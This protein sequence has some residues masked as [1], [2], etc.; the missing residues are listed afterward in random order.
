MT[1]MKTCLVALAACAVAAP[2]MA[3][4]VSNK[5]EVTVQTSDLDLNNPRDADILL[6]RINK[7]AYKTCKDWETVIPNAQ[8]SCVKHTVAENVARLNINALG[9]A[10]VDTYGEKPALASRD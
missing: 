2:A 7:A 3:D 8:R 1:I 6:Q 4:V 5:K 9:M 10:Y